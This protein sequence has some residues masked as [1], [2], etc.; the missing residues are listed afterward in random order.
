MYK[1]DVLIIGAGAAGLFCA[2]LAK[3]KGLNV[4]VIDHAK[5]IAEKVRISGGG[6][7]NF[8]NIDLDPH[9]PSK[10]FISENPRFCTSALSRYTPQDFVQWM[11]KHQIPFHEKHKGQLFCD[12]S[13]ED[14]IEAL[15]EEC[16]SG[17]NAAEVKIIHTCKLEQLNFHD[18]DKP[19]YEAL[20]TEGTIQSSAVVVATGGLSIPQ[21]GASDLGY[22]LAQQFGLRVTPTRAALVP[23]VFEP[24]SWSVF[25]SLSGLS[26]PV[27]I[28]TGSGKRKTTFEEDLLFTH[29]G[30][31]GPAALQISSYWQAQEEIMINLLPNSPVEAHLLALKQ[32][33]KKLLITE[34]SAQLPHRLA[35]AWSLQ[36]PDWLKSMP[37]LSNKS[38]QHIVQTLQNWQLKPHGTE[39]YKKAEVTAGGVDTKDLSQQTLESKQKGLYFIGEVVDITGWLGGYNFQWAWSSAFA[40]AEGLANQ[41]N[42]L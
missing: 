23:L 27:S 16:H 11:R 30:L 1:T 25:S 22:R 34:L 3:Q 32:Q 42:K 7:S 37:D 33:S 40:C 9:Q 13:S 19:Y 17:G 6:R 10:H 15:L 18:H 8:T 41:L 38:I 39:G 20:T 14:L 4:M 31:S 21:I 35:Q 2:G 26:L 24:S 12:R 36:N 5:K 28:Q 29:K